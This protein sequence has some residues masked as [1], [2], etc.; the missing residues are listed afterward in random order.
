MVSKYCVNVGFEEDYMI[1]H[2]S[3][4]KHSAPST[5]SFFEAKFSDRDATNKKQKIPGENLSELVEDAERNKGLAD[6]I[7]R[8]LHNYSNLG[9]LTPEKQEL[10]RIVSNALSGL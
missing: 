1:I 7:S 2:Y 9:T 6:E 8:E 5:L 10:I 3:L 4:G